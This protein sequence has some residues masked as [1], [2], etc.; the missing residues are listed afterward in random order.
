MD[1]RVVKEKE[2]IGEIGGEKLGRVKP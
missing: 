2:G 1:F